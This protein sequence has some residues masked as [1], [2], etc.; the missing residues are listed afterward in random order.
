MDEDFVAEELEALAIEVEGGLLNVRDA[1]FI[2]YQQ[3][4]EDSSVDAVVEE[5]DDDP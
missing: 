1:L 3:G 4:T 2:A 5:I